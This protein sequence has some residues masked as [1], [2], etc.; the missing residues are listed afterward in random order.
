MILNGTYTKHGSIEKLIKI[1]NVIWVG[2][3]TYIFIYLNK[4]RA[5]VVFD[6][7]TYAAVYV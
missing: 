3:Y 5:D 7:N 2:T 4:R 6:Y 1:K